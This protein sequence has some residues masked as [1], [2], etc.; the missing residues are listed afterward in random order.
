MVRNVPRVVKNVPR[1]ADI[2]PRMVTLKRN[3]ERE[4]HRDRIQRENGLI[5]SKIS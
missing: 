1:V 5:A 2:V 4:R 3:Q